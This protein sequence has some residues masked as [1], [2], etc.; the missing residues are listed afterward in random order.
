MH[1][2]RLYALRVGAINWYLM[3]TRFL[4]FFLLLPALL[5]GQG[6]DPAVRL[7]IMLGDGRTVLGDVDVTL[8]QSVAPLTVQNFLRYANRGA[9]NNTVFHRSVPG[10]IVQT[11]GY[12][13]NGNDFT[14]KVAQDPPVRN[15]YNLPNVRG[16]LAMAKLDRQPNSATNEFFF[17]LADNITGPNSLNTQNGGFTVFGRVANAA[18]QAVIDRIALPPSN[19]F[20]QPWNEMPL[21][22][23]RGGI[24]SAA[25]IIVIS[26]ITNLDPVAPPAITPDGVRMAGAFG[27][28]TKAAPGSYIE[29]YG[30]GMA[31]VSR[32]WTDADFLGSVAPITLESVQVTV[33]GIRAYISYVSPTQ[34][35]VQVPEGVAAGDAV[36]V[37]VSYNGVSTSPSTIAVREYAGGLLAPAA[38]KVGDVQYAAA[39]HNANGKFVSGGNIPNVDAAPAVPGETLVFYGVG[40]GPITPNFPPLGGRKATGQTMVTNPVT[41]KI[42]ENEAKVTYAGLAP[43]LIGLYQFNVEVPSNAPSG[44]LP[45]TVTQGG[46]PIAQTLVIAVKAP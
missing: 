34:I 23:Y 24:P 19:F 37:I 3:S 46:S 28:A 5:L 14:T 35:N 43:G 7:R 31:G 20:Q 1:R 27:G 44:D 26:S 40:F 42:G 36:P 10:F 13:L 17:N 6:G 32:S 8:L 18:S 38:F 21:F 25:N 45:V 16:T 33:G 9:Y 22:N 11:G 30:T 12:I 29:I 15:E 4:G 39:V 41:F 2:F